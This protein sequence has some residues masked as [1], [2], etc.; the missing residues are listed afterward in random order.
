MYPA[1][2]DSQLRQTIERFQVSPAEL[3]H[4][5]QCAPDTKDARLNAL[6]NEVDETV[7][8]K[9]IKLHQK[10]G[11]VAILTVANR[12]I[13][14]LSIEDVSPQKVL[15]AGCLAHHLGLVAQST[16][17]MSVHAPSAT[18]THE[19]AQGVAAQTVKNAL[20]SNEHPPCLS[21]FIEITSPPAHARLAWQ[22]DMQKCTYNGDVSWKEILEGYASK[23]TG[24]L[25]K[26]KSQKLF[27]SG[28]AIGCILPLTDEMVVV[29]CI[30]NSSGTAV[31]LTE[32]EGLSCVAA[33][34]NSQS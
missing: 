28:K 6:L 15:S 19:T 18:K 23:I 12:R 14:D 9:D 33:W 26:N 34:Q 8:A 17:H 1:R 2:K 11:T 25:Q 29:V 22:N 30:E 10:D 3:A 13:C 32:T 20:S 27:Q 24:T 31:V 21:G 5:R 16:T 4:E 7:L